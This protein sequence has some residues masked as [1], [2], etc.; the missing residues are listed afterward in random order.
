MGMWN[1][2]GWVGTCNITNTAILLFFYELDSIV[3]SIK[4]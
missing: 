3:S 2:S 4:N 1:N